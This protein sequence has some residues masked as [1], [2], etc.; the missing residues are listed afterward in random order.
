MNNEE[1]YSEPI[2]TAPGGTLS[3]EELAE[4][5][6]P[7]GWDED[8]TKVDLP[9]LPVKSYK[10]VQNYSGETIGHVGGPDGCDYVTM[11][12]VGK[13]GTEEEAIVDRIK[14]QATALDRGFAE[15]CFDLL[16]A[17]NRGIHIHRGYSSFPAWV[18]SLN[19]GIRG[20]QAYYYAS[21]AASAL[22]LG[23]SKEKMTEIG[24]SKL[25]EIFS[26]DQVAQQ[27]EIGALLQDAATYKLAQIQEAVAK[28]KGKDGAETFSFITIKIPESARGLVDHAVEIVKGLAG[29]DE[30]ELSLGQCI[31]LICSEFLAGVG[32]T[33]TPKEVSA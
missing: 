10:I 16:E 27:S 18:D 14:S 12:A 32:E 19:I 4:A 7:K 33:Y 6:K 20:R 31:E 11:V 25:K 22:S 5:L 28:L 30:Q 29:T 17:R 9:P 21:V 13:E 26:L 2:Y 15:L 1:V 23:V 24:I 3:P 8:V